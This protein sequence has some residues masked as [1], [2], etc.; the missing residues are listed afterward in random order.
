MSEAN[1]QTRFIAYLRLSLRLSR[2]SLS[3]VLLQCA[4]TIFAPA[5]N[6]NSCSP[7]EKA[8]AATQQKKGN[9]SRETAAR[10]SA[11]RIETCQQAIYFS[12]F[13]WPPVFGRCDLP[14]PLFAL[15]SLHLHNAQ[16][17]TTL[18]NHSVYSISLHV[19]RTIRLLAPRLLLSEC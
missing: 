1:A 3:F 15:F 8:K 12:R 18:D 10:F 17:I 14:F 19:A 7:K 6:G 5:F 9:E 13:S 16:W 11:D 4:A 2:L